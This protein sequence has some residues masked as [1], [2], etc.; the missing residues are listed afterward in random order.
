LTV[1]SSEET[2]SNS[3][4]IADDRTLILM[5]RPD[6]IP[7]S[8]IRNNL[9]KGYKSEIYT[10]FRIQ[11][12]GNPLSISG[13]HLEIHIRKTGFLDLITGDYILLVNDREAGVYRNWSDFFRAF[14][15]V[16]IYPS[17][18]F[19]EDGFSP[20]IRVRVRVIYKKLVPPFSIL[21]LLPGKYVNAGRWR[22]VLPGE[23][24]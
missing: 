4:A 19:V 9:E 6:S 8:Y 17:G 21:Y 12:S 2:N 22:D 7:E 13:E 5:S 11:M 16:L 10:S 24:P 1:L 14:S 3:Y 20:K 18:I 23:L 15:A